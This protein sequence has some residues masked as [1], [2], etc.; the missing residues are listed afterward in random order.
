MTASITVPIH[1]EHTFFVDTSDIVRVFF[2]VVSTF[3]SIRNFITCAKLVVW[4]FPPHILV[5]ADDAF[6][7]WAQLRIE[8]V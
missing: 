3:N 4:L 6:D 2:M 1:V 5:F 8:K 7:A